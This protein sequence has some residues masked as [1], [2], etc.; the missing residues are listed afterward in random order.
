MRSSEYNDENDNTNNF[1]LNLRQSTKEIKKKVLE[2]DYSYEKH[3]K[4][5][6]FV[7]T[8]RSSS[9]SNIDKISPVYTTR[10]Q[11]SIENTNQSNGLTDGLLAKQMNK[12]NLHINNNL[13]Q[14][15]KVVERQKMNDTFSNDGWKKLMQIKKQSCTKPEPEIQNCFSNLTRK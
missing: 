8:N 3:N 5:Q 9:M 1:K 2:D 7:Q 15:D 14:K 4:P 11:A 13:Q 12:L 10:E 6:S